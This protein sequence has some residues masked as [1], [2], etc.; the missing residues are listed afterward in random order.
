MNAQDFHAYLVKLAMEAYDATDD[1]TGLREGKRR[2]FRTAVTERLAQAAQVFAVSS[3]PSAE[4]ER[5]M[6]AHEAEVRAAEAK[7]AHGRGEMVDR[8]IHCLCGAR[9]EM[10]RAWDTYFCPASGTW[11]ESMCVDVG[12]TYCAERPPV[13]GTEGADHA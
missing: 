7:P 2:A 4:E 10:D 9:G 1:T 5:E 3:L 13:R 11:L 12:C 6:E 8:V